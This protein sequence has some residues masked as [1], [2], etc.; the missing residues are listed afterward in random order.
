MALPIH[1][2]IQLFVMLIYLSPP[3]IC[4]KNSGKLIKNQ[5]MHPDFAP[6]EL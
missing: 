4:T 2:F 3:Y 6:V 1:Y 5:S